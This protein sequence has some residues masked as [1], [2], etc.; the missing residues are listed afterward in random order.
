MACYADKEGDGTE[1]GERCRRQWKLLN[2]LSKNTKLRSAAW[3][4]R[5]DA[6]RRLQSLTFPTSEE[7]KETQNELTPLTPQMCAEHLL[8]AMCCAGHWA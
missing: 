1:K 8:S 3:M 2:Q 4:R 7:E 6:Y 5:A